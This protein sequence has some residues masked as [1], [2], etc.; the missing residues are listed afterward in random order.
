M[1]GIHHRLPRYMALAALLVYVLTLS[2][3]TTLNSLPMA[4]KVAGWDWQPM[5][6]EPLT[7][8]L[9][10]PLRCLPAGWIPISLNL[11]FAI[12]GAFTLGLLA[13][14]IE[15]LPWDCPPD[16]NKKW[17]KP[18]PVLLACAVCGLEFNF[19]QEATAATGV[20]LNQLLLAAGIW[21]L[22]EY[23]AGKEARWLNA[24]AL[25]WGL[26]MAQ[27]WV[28]LLN[29]PLFVA[30][31]IWLRR[32]RFFKWT[33]L[34]RMA[35]LGLAGFSIYALLPLVNGM[36]PHS[37]WSFGEAWLATLKITKHT[38]GTLYH[39]FWAWHRLMT[40][41]V[42]LYFLVPTLPGLVRLQDRG[43]KN[44]SKVERLQTVSYT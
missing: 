34:R 44:K 1:A 43:G 24:A 27:N 38:F 4:A 5:A 26:G 17:I 9:T 15:L 28:M 29:L 37:P 39:Q 40:L 3:G 12:C 2:C 6:N 7:W 16:E 10:L 20:M 30:A 33:F 19:W 32:R 22:L 36:N 14:S 23:R 41:V 11:F 13:R 18:L 25:I 42:V 8:L 35:L 21:C 31:L